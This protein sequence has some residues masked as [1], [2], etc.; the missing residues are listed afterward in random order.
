MT[1]H[2]YGLKPLTPKAL[3]SRNGMVVVVRIPAGTPEDVAEKARQAAKD[4]VEHEKK[5]K[6]VTWDTKKVK[7]QIKLL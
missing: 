3:Y 2:K 4:L 6:R 1:K 5:Q 7:G